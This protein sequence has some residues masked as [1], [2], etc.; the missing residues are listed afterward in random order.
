MRTVY[1]SSPDIDK[2]SARNRGY[3]PE[4]R[5]SDFWEFY[6]RCKPYSLVGVTGFFNLYRSMHYIA[7]N[8]IPGDFVECGV[9]LGGCA[10]F[11][12]LLRDALGLHDRHLYLYDTYC[13]FP[14]G[15]ADAIRGTPQPGH[16]IERF[17]TDVQEHLATVCDGGRGITMIEGPVEETL[18]S[19][20][21]PAV[22][23][24]RLDTDF[25]SST[26]AELS[27]I[28]PHL[29]AGGVLIVDDYGLYDGARRA[30]DEYL[31]TLDRVP[32]LNR[33]DTT[34]WSGIKPCGSVLEK[35]NF[36]K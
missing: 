8:A 23:L 31:A 25:Y 2:R 30:T 10:M 34:V 9:F 6:D 32:S 33:I 7:R 16:R 11:V 4:I 24:L 12:A 28:Y 5:E 19:F 29:S 3:Y 15:A 20:D 14:E 36:P 13:G 18:R 1:E 27:A 17:Y 22:S 26:A 35:M 21:V